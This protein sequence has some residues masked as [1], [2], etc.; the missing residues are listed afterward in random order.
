MSEKGPNQPPFL[1]PQLG[2]VLKYKKPST[3][4]GNKPCLNQY[5]DWYHGRN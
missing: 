5:L 2:E 3:Q 4:E 1:C